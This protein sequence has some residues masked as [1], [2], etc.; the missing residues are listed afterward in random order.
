MAA[1]LVLVGHKSRA[2]DLTRAVGRYPVG[3]LVS[4][5]PTDLVHLPHVP[6][7]SHCSQSARVANWL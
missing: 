1:P 6:E 2:A 5:A 3:D 7:G 4:V